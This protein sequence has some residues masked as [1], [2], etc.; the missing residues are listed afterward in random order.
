MKPNKIEKIILDIYRDLYKN[1]TP[2]ADFDYLVETAELN[3]RHE[4]II[5][6]MDYAI[7]ET[8]YHKIVEKHLKR[9][10]MSDYYKDSI[11]RTVLLG[12]SPT[13]KK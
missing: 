4:K 11:R 12:C 3:D 7:E 13:F 2:S 5:H 10:K 1:S 9:K 6:Y 8:E